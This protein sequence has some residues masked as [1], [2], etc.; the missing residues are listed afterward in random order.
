MRLAAG[1]MRLAVYPTGNSRCASW[2]RCDTRV[3]ILQFVHL[4][5][6]DHSRPPRGLGSKILPKRHRTSR[7]WH[8][9]KTPLLIGDWGQRQGTSE[10]R[11]PKLVYR[12]PGSG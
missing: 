8:P 12:F 1:V 2:G 10:P 4:L 6:Y 11:P 5:M 9:C 3:D 7:D